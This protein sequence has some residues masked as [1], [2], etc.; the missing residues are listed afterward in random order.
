MASSLTILFSKNSFF[1]LI[2]IFK[3]WS[4][5]KYL[6]FNGIYSHYKFP[7]VLLYMNA[8]GFTTS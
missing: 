2:Y 5:H 4:I 1:R 6:D 8:R 7:Q 3:M